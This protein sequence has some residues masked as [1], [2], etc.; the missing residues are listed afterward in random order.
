MN[1]YE[2]LGVSPNASDDEI[3]KAYRQLV[4]KYH[5]DRYAGNASAQTQQAAMRHRH[6]VDR[7][8]NLELKNETSK[9]RPLFLCR[10]LRIQATFSWMSPFVE[11]GHPKAKI[12][13]L[14][15]KNEKESNLNLEFSCS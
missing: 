13:K 9:F 3:K 7:G 11:M 14:Q 8:R 6:H 12:E 1:P 10:K 2:V 5:P 15:C 4:K